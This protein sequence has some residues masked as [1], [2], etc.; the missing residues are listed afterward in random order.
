MASRGV[1][2]D[3]HELRTLEF[4]MDGAPAR[5]RNPAGVIRGARIIEREMWVDAQGHVGSY[6]TPLKRH[7]R[8]MRPKVSHDLIG[9]LTAE[10]GIEKGPKG[11]PEADG[12]VFHL[13]AYGSVNNAAVYDP[14]AGPRRAMPRVLNIL[15]DQTEESVLG[16]KGKR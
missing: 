8:P 4:D 11:S 12:N 6:F 2:F 13:L 7:K 10:I 9:P 1:N 14:G 5:I 16:E 15:A 3:T